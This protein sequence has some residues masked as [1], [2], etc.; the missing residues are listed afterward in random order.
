MEI[1]LGPTILLLVCSVHV[2]SGVKN[3]QELLK[4]V[5]PLGLFLRGWGVLFLVIPR[6]GSDS[7]RPFSGIIISR[8]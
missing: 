8:G 7:I 3:D 1:D 5:I 6:S 4:W 2:Q